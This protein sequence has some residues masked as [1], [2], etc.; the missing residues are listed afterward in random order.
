MGSLD[1][2]YPGPMRVSP[3]RVLVAI[4]LLV[5]AVERIVVWRSGLGALDG[6][7]AVWGLM[8]R[9]VL[10]GE[11]PAFFWGQGY[12]GTLEVFLSVPLLAVA[13]TSVVALRIVPVAL[14]LVAVYLVWRVGRRTI[15]EPAAT[16]AAVLFWVW[17]SYAIW[18]S[19]RAHGF[20]ASG[21][22]L[23]LLVL[24]LVLRLAE[25]PARSDAILLGFVLGVSGWQTFQILPIAVG[26]LGW[27]AWKR[28][29]LVRELPYA[30]V[31]A[32]VGFLPW[33]VSNLANGW[34]TFHFPPGG[35]TYLSRFRGSVN[36]TLPMAFG[37]RVP[38]EQGWIG[39]FLIGATLFC[40]VVLLLAW[41]GVRRLREPFGLLVVVAVVFPFLMAFSTFTWLV[42]EPRYVYILSPVI[43]LLVGAL[44]TTWPR[45][46]AG[47]CAAVVLSISGLVIVHGSDQYRQRA[48]GLAVPRHFGPLI[49]E[50][51]R[52][53]IT[54]VYADYWVA[55]RLAFESGER[56]IAAQ[57]PQEMY[58]RDGNR[59]VVLDPGNMRRPQF[60]TIVRRS[61]RPGHVVVRGTSDERKLDV[62]LLRSAGYRPFVV[63]RFVVWAPP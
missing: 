13:P 50:L 53:G 40:G 18:K 44:L 55:Y 56:I 3:L 6:D 34:W 31:A 46:L 2:G 63:G 25:R 42:D 28:P 39:G 21:L 8:A 24:L 54:R 20:Y 61:A 49:D 10:D 17:P 37:V 57:S 36:G 30:L 16:A 38:F 14:T 52:R 48:D 26:S 41:I 11:L 9:H 45:M 60:D 62:P 33:I 51:E 7:E 12:G 27:L 23:C 29:G 5:G 1:A 59:V 15:G 19:I 43:A 47:L 35:G 32:L 4:G 22:V 58:H